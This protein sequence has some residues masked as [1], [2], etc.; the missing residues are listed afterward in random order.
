M[1]KSNFNQALSIHKTGSVEKIALT[2]G[3]LGSSM[4]QCSAL[5]CS[6]GDQTGDACC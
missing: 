5:G 4:G 6:G 3:P 2:T 1:I